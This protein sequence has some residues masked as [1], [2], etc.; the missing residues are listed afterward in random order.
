MSID[1][2]VSEHYQHGDL[3]CAIEAATPALGRTIDS[4][5]TEDLAPVENIFLKG[6]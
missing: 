5:A 1:K 2:S 4:I 6:H 3:L